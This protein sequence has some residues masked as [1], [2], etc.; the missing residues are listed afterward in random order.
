MFHIVTFTVDGGWGRWTAY[1]PCSKTCA[2]GKH[3]RTRK[4]NKPYPS[5]PGALACLKF[6]DT[7]RAIAE[8]QV[9]ICNSQACDRECYFLYKRET[10]YMPGHQKQ[11]NNVTFSSRP[12]TFLNNQF[13]I[14]NI[15]TS[16]C[17]CT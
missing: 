15:V 9:A 4:C 3:R 6:N 13:D 11:N 7:V 14:A 12:L 17:V 5:G 16:K 1:T 8:T 2:G 10:T